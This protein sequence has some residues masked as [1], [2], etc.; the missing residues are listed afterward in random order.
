[1]RDKILVPAKRVVDQRGRNCE[2]EQSWQRKNLEISP[3]Q[4]TMITGF[5]WQRRL[6]AQIF[7][8][9]S[10]FQRPVWCGGIRL[11]LAQNGVEVLVRMSGVTSSMQFSKQRELLEAR[12]N[13]SGDRLLLF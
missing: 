2:W 8:V 13:H 4:R 1:M 9:C 10:E 7:D 6:L 3:S 11:R 5:R 12:L